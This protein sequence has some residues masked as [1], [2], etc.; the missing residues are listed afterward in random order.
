MVRAVQFQTPEGWLVL[1]GKAPVD[2]TLGL[3][4]IDQQHILDG[5]RHISVLMKI[6]NPELFFLYSCLSRNIDLGF[7]YTAEAEAVQEEVAGP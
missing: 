4:G 2:S 5:A 6:M 7:N 1:C 3:G